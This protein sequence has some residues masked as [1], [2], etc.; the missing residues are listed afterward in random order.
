MLARSSFTLLAGIFDP[1]FATGLLQLCQI[2]GLRPWTVCMFEIFPSR[3]NNMQVWRLRTT[4]GPPLFY[5]Q[6]F[7]NRLSRTFMFGS[8]SCTSILFHPIINCWVGTQMKPRSCRLWQLS[9]TAVGKIVCDIHKNPQT[10]FTDLPKSM[11]ETNVQV[12]T[13]T[14]RRQLNSVGFW[15]RITWKSLYFKHNIREF[16]C[17]TLASIQMSPKPSGNKLFGLVTPK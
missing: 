15:G 12:S 3:F 9:D 11:K 6:P 4:G 2:V 17:N 1:F 8:L 5:S 13:S 10:A 14:K 16:K 7:L